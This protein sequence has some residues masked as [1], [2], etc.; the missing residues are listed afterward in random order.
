MWRMIIFTSYTEVLC[1]TGGEVD[2][3]LVI[4]TE[5]QFRVSLTWFILIFWFEGERWCRK[6]RGEKI[7]E[8]GAFILKEKH[9]IHLD[10]EAGTWGYSSIQP[11]FSSCLF[12][13]FTASCINSL[14][15]THR[16]TVVFIWHHT[17]FIKVC[18]MCGMKVV[19][20][21]AVF[22]AVSPC[23]LAEATDAWRIC[24]HSIPRPQN[25]SD[26][27]QTLKQWIGSVWQN[28]AGWINHWLYHYNITV[29]VCFM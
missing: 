16:K 8:G 1:S 24:L 26:T 17:V 5:Q 22:P 10:T 12:D 14:C 11:S 4:I 23:L 21:Y 28:G 19:A 7:E 3:V 15:H 27:H 29:Y 18:V 9:L 2:G 6:G 25:Y 13:P 20:E